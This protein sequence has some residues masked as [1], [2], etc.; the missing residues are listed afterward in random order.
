MN[1]LDIAV[2]QGCGQHFRLDLVYQR[3]LL[4]FPEIKHGRST[5]KSVEPV[6]F[7]VLIEE[8]HHFKAFYLIVMDSILLGMYESVGLERHFGESF[9]CY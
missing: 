7:G 4:F 3:Y 5:A 2:H 8:S 6:Q 1:P 9:S